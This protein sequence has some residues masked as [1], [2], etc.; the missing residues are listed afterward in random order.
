MVANEHHRHNP[1]LEKHRRSVRCGKF[2]LAH[3]A[4]A[5]RYLGYGQLYHEPP[6]GLQTDWRLLRESH[7]GRTSP[8][9]SHVETGQRCRVGCFRYPAETCL[10]GL[11]QTVG[12]WRKGLPTGGGQFAILHPH[13]RGSRRRSRL[14]LH[15]VAGS[16]TDA[17]VGGSATGRSIKASLARQCRR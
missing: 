6:E 14:A 7:P 15:L 2:S 3:R 8:H 11:H 4:R 10:R 16:D 17:C 5:S 1:A 9:R 12:W 13:R